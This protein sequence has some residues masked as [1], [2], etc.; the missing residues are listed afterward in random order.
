MKKYITAT[1]QIMQ[2]FKFICFTYYHVFFLEIKLDH[3]R[4]NDKKKIKWT[5][6]GITG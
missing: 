6:L 1:T 4:N 3:F 5:F 2:K